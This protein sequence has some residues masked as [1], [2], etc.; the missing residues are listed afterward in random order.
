M[1][2][3]LFYRTFLCL[4][5]GSV[6]AVWG[7]GSAPAEELFQKGLSA[8]QNKQYAEARESFQKLLDLG[9]TEGT[10]SVAVMHNLALSALQLD[11]KAFALALWRKALAVE[12]EYAPARRGRDMLEGKMQMR[13]LE[14]DGM[15]LWMHRTLESM[16]IYELLW[17]TAF[18]LAVTGGL[19]L[20]YLGVRRNAL[21]AEL[22]LPPF[23]VV[24]VVVGFLLVFCLSLA[25]LKVRDS[26][27]ARATV[28][29]DKVSARALPT[30]DG[31]GLFEIA[32]GS[33]VLVRRRQEG[34]TQVQSGDGGSGWV[35]DAEIL[36]TAGR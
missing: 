1:L 32:A 15:G 35:R 3:S 17:L 26:M 2:R 7:A 6:G 4:C 13:T 24:A 28:I 18:T 12:P 25:G 9:A 30:D 23:P 14:R 8:Y 10:V 31:V 22:P 16:S 36:I 29:A 33:E 21:E 34:W 11:Q 19:G 20:R 27:S 5:I